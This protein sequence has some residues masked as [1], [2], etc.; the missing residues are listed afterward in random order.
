MTIGLQ[1]AQLAR[2]EQELEFT[3][4]GVVL[5]LVYSHA[6]V[7]EPFRVQHSLGI[8]PEIVTWLG[9]TDVRVWAE[10]GDE[11]LWNENVVVLRCNVALAPL[12]LLVI[13]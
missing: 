7:M 8:R 6:T 3:L 13:G 11:R 4:R 1:D 9:R 10:E 2:I 12:R 5:P